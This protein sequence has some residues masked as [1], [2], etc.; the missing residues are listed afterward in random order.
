VPAKEIRGR[1]DFREIKD[2]SEERFTAEASHV[3]QKTA[4]CFQ[5]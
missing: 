4:E 5:P 2:N 3:I 1:L